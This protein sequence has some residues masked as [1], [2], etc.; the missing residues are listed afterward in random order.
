MAQHGPPSF[1][2]GSAARLWACSSP[3]N[4][5]N[6]SPPAQGLGKSPSSFWL[7]SFLPP[8]LAL[9]SQLHWRAILLP[10]H[11]AP[12]RQPHPIGAGGCSSSLKPKRKSLG[13]CQVLRGQCWAEASQGRRNRVREGRG[14][15]T[16]TGPPYPALG[17]TPA[18]APQALEGGGL[19]GEWALPPGALFPQCW[20]LSLCHLGPATADLN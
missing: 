5:K 4:S 3:C 13:L 15:G 12:G 16:G 6:R 9:L 18:S 1:L 19:A 8:V 17:R 11:R 7:A 2:C 14:S 10:S 20:P